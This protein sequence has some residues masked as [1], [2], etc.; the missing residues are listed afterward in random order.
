[1]PGIA[2][3]VAVIHEGKILLTK[4]EDFEVW[5]LPSGEVEEGESLAEAAIRET[6]E[7]TGVDIELT[8]L[9]GVYSRLGGMPDVHAVLYEAKPIGGELR[10]QPGETTEVKYF[11]FDKIPQ[12]IAFAH[13]KR[14]ADALN[15]SSGMSVKQ[16]LQSPDGVTVDRQTLYAL[17][18][19][20][21]LPRQRF[22][23]Q[24]IEGA[25]TSETVQLQNGHHDTPSAKWLN[26][27][28]ELYSIAQ[29]GLT[30]CKNEYD[31]YSYRRLREISAEIIAC[32]S[33]LSRET[34]MQAF[35]MQA[36]YATPKIDVRGAVFHEGRILLVQEKADGKWAM[37]GGW[38]DIGDLPSA[39]VERE[40]LEEAGFEVKAVK[41]AAI[42]DANRI[43]PLEFFH[44]FKIIFLCN[45]L[46]GSARPN[47]ETL[48]VDF[49]DFNNLPPLSSGRTNESMLREI[50]A[51]RE[52]PNRPAAFD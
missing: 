44:A 9:V 34:V 21:G 32:R 42:Y 19:R 37:P 41:V 25:Q 14:I 33:E 10:L 48:A 24:Q 1:M 8:R 28:R 16:E 30:Y 29:A 27:A 15:S 20:S 12:A 7:E 50:F 17:R 2:V 23:L 49:F 18:D 38:A 39:M 40:V 43:D 36:G 45:L 22:Y 52:D 13:K 4:R 35:S 3:N 47:H 31:L 26:L 11:T 51:H 6:K 5:C 46:G